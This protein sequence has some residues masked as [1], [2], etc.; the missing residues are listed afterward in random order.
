MTRWF[1]LCALWSAAALAQP[2]ELEEPA[3]PRIVELKEKLVYSK[4]GGGQGFWGVTVHRNGEELN[5]GL[6]GGDAEAFF[7]EIPESALLARRLRTERTV[8]VALYVSGAAL[9]L[10]ETVY[11]LY[12]LLSP[13]RAIL[14]DGAPVMVGTLIGGAALAGVGGYFLQKSIGTLSET[15]NRFNAGLLNRLLPPSQR[16]DMSIFASRDGAGVSAAWTF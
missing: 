13:N 8:G 9:L 4:L 7:S 16:I 10:A 11:F 3:D 1:A 12:G 14:N 6:L 5:L 15:V 2:A